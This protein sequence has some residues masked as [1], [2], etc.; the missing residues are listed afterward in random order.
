MSQVEHVATDT[1][2]VDVTQ[3]LK[4]FT[5]SLVLLWS[6]HMLCPSYCLWGRTELQ[7]DLLP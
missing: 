2:V 5:L 3:V 1:D 6:S 7:P 4:Y